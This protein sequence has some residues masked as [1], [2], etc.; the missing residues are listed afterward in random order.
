MAT[1]GF[2]WQAKNTGL[3][4]SQCP[5]PKE[6]LLDFLKEKGAPYDVTYII[7]CQEN[8]QDGNKHLHAALLL[9]KT[10]NIK[11]AERFFDLEGFH[12]NVQVLRNVQ[13]WIEYVKKHGDFI[14]FGTCPEFVG[15][16]RVRDEIAME[17]DGKSTREEFLAVMKEKNPSWLITS[18]I[19]IS[20]YLDDRYRADPPRYVSP[21]PTDSWKP[22][23]RV[24]LW[25]EETRSPRD[26]YD[27][28]V[29]VGP[30][31]YGKTSYI[32]S[33][34]FHVYWKSYINVSTLISGVR[35]GAG[36][37]VVDDPCYESDLDSFPCGKTILLGTAGTLT[38]KYTRKTDLERGLPCV[39][40]CN[41]LPRMSDY[42][43]ENSIV[44]HVDSPLF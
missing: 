1:E 3:T 8:H 37:L 22:I 12:P 11:K 20:R 5:L 30:T 28:L 15:K 17:A 39:Y 33:K 40:L 2:R 41:E 35:E 38:D 44:V 24:E 19:S 34:G 21:Y 42:W 16:K 13:K 18:Y 29:L 26:R 36:F 9:A 23:P 10:P 6:R 7:V 25:F 43:R 4:Y 32:R 31:K 27:L 14:E